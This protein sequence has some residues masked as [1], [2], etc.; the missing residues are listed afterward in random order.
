MRLVIKTFVR[1][2]LSDART[3]FTQALFLKLNPPFPPVKLKQFDGC[4]TGDIVHLE[5]NFLL[6]WQEW[7]SL[8][9]RDGNDDKEWWF[10]DEGTKLP[11][12]LKTWKH[13]HRVVRVT[14]DISEIID[15]VTFST[16]TI[17]TDLLMYPALYLQFVYRK[18]IYKRFFDSPKGRK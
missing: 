16:G 9:T 18:P 8:I 5:L 14:A 10:I 13:H 2:S 7:I 4:K 3:G 15:D 6:F 1:S 17:L 12:F 11:F